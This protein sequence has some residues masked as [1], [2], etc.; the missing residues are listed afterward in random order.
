[1]W[2]L[3]F[4]LLV[5]RL[6]LQTRDWTE[7]WLNHR[8][9][10][11]PPRH[12]PEVPLN[13]WPPP[14]PRHQLSPVNRDSSGHKAC[15]GLPVLTFVII[16]VIM[17]LNGLYCADVPLS[18]YSLTYCHC[19]VQETRLSIRL[20]LL[21]AFGALSSLEEH[22]VSELLNSILPLELAR[23]IQNDLSGD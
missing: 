4:T 17:A 14:Q 15:M 3:I 16:T 13:H 19:Y 23:D 6:V 22:I 8:P 11:P 1:M 9:P 5:C 20:L 18:N 21:Q 2:F 12:Q 10:P 7:V